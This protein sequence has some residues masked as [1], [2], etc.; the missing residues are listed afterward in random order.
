M[1]TSFAGRAIRSFMRRD[2]R[3]A[4][5]EQLRVTPARGEE[6]DRMVDALGDV[7]VEPCW[8]HA[9]ASWIARQ[10]RSGVAGIWM[11]FTPRWE[12]ASTTAL[13]TAGAAAIVPVSPTPFTPSGFVGLG[14]SVRLE[15]ERRELGRRGHEVRDEVRRLQVALVVVHALLVQRRGD[16]LRDPAVHLAVDDQRVDH[17]ADVVDRDVADEPR[18]AGLGVDLDDRRVRAAGPREVRRVVR[19][20][21]L[22]TRLHPVRQVVR[23]ERRP[24]GRRRWSSP[25]RASPS[26]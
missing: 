13:I 25:C 3:M 6:L 4:A 16:A 9:F 15:L 7:V 1:S 12:S 10:T 17:R 26:R 24:G 20:R 14:L 21:R 5:R 23:G 11:S 22:E 2:Q 18:V 19:R 8:D